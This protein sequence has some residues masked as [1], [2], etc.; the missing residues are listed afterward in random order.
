MLEKEI[1][2]LA[3]VEPVMRIFSQLMEWRL[4]G[5]YRFE[6]S[7]PDEYAVWVRSASV[8]SGSKDA[9]F[10]AF[11]KSMRKIAQMMKELDRLPK[12]SRAFRRKVSQFLRLAA[13]CA[14]VGERMTER[15]AVMNG[16]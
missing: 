2:A 10:R 15:L 3:A 9:D 5:S 11:G 4:P 14:R 8:L 13:Q 1:D 16:V 6:E 7:F 12:E